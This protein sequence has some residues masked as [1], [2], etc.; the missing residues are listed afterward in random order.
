MI[1]KPEVAE[2]RT[3][4]MV[5]NYIWENPEMNFDHVGNSFLCLLQVAT[6]KGWIDI[7][8]NAVDSREVNNLFNS[9]NK[10]L[11]EFFQGR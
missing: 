7:M 6:F 11:I 8:A 1:Q 2:N 10:L 4:C 9:D 5:L 3:E